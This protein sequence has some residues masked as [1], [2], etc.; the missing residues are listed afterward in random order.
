MLAAL[1]LQTPAF[2]GGTSVVAVAAGGVALLCNLSF[3]LRW[4]HRM[5]RLETLV[6]TLLKKHGYTRDLHDK[7]LFWR[8][9]DDTGMGK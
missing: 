1:L 4:E 6:E 8:E 9:T 2:D 7:R 5:T 3:W